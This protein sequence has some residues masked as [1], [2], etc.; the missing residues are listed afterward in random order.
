MILYSIYDGKGNFFMSPFTVQNDEV[1]Q[2]HIM[3]TMME[4]NH[5]MTQHAGDYTLYAIAEFNEDNGEVLGFPPR[6]IVN[7]GAL[8]Q[9]VYNRRLEFA[10]IEETSTATVDDLRRVQ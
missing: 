8:R 4:D 2:R 6:A 1:A 9:M 3:S 7:L 5:P 10:D